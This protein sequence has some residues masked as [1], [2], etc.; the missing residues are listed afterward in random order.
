MANKPYFQ[1]YVVDLE[2]DPFDA[3]DFV[4]RLAWRITQDTE[5]FDVAYLKRKFEEEIGSLQNSIETWQMKVQRFEDVQ[6]TAKHRYLDSLQRLHDRNNEAVD[7]L[8]QLDGTMQTISAKVVHLGDQLDS[9]HAPR[10]RAFEALQLMKHFDEFF[11]DQPLS[12]PI[13][14]EP[15]RLLESAEMIQKLASISQ[16][17]VRDSFHSVQQRIARKYEEIEEL[18]VKEFERTVDRKRLHEIARILADF[19]CFTRCVDSFVERAQTG[20]FRS[21]NVFEDVQHVCEKT[22]TLIDEI[23]PNPHQVMN[24]LILNVFYGKLRD[25]VNAKLQDTENEPEQYLI[26]LNDLYSKT[27]KLGAILKVYQSES[28]PAF[29]STLINSIFDSYRS[30]YP[31][32]EENFI[33]QQ[34]TAILDRFYDSKG[35]KKRQIYS[36]SI[37]ELKRDV[38]ARLLTVENYGGETF[39]SEEVAI[40]ILQEFKNAFARCN[41]LCRK[42]QVVAM[43]QSIF[44]LLL[45]HLY[46]DHVDYAI[47]LALSGISLAE[48]KTE[49]PTNFFAIVQQTTAITHLFMKQ[50]DDLIFAVVKDT[51]V[52]ESVINKRDGTLRNVENQINLGLER[53]IN[54]FVGYVRYLLNTEQKKSDFKPEDESRGIITMSTACSSVVRYVTRMHDRIRD[55]IDGGNLK[56]VLTEF[57]LR[58]YNVIINHIKNYNY[59]IAGTMLLVCDVNEYRKCVADWGIAEVRRN[60]EALHALVNLMVVVPENLSET[61]AAPALS[62]VDQSLIS[63]FVSLRHDARTAKLYLA[64]F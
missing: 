17:L 4:E 32:M 43:N 21:G 64:R 31:Q 29:V 7:R 46:N 20:A 9:V 57:G 61:A 16:E 25:T 39:L 59:N 38:Q 22:K 3:T 1:T 63:T 27:L 37:H 6:S 35:H 58:F 15:D 45:K 50:F 33:R 53:Q 48:P 40:N 5:N 2:Q 24:K 41:L 19:K 34:C 28:D 42:Q 44:D 30:T 56:A 51:A 52:E 11:A 55:N 10:A 26:S 60:F 13:F 8:K 49:P 18:L 36:G 54:A 12:S 14:T 62:I 47:D 23:F